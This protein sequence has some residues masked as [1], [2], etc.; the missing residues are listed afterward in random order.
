MENQRDNCPSCGA[1]VTGKSSLCALCGAIYQIEKSKVAQIGQTCFLCGHQTEIVGDRCPLC[2]AI[3]MVECPSCDFEYE[4]GLRECPACGY[5]T[6]KESEKPVEQRGGEQK[7]FSMKSFYILRRVAVVIA[8]MAGIFYLFEKIDW[9]GPTGFLGFILI[10]AVLSVVIVYVIYAPGA[11]PPYREKKKRS[12]GQGRFTMVYRTL[13]LPR[14]EHLRSL[15]NSEGVP[16][17]IYNQHATTLD[18]FDIFTGIRIMVPK[19]RLKETENI[20]KAFDFET[21]DVER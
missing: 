5:D 15:L 13:D 10:F 21:D 8:L 19:E 2:N 17:F 1:L 6:A 7:V 3:Y 9:H 18:P 12:K 16:A 20:M 11:G 4:T 14:A